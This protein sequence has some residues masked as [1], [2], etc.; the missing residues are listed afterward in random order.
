MLESGLRWISYL[1]GHDVLND[2]TTARAFKVDPT[3]LARRYDETVS[4]AE[5]SST[6]Y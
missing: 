2:A 6:Y 1:D 3:T 4:S 5:V